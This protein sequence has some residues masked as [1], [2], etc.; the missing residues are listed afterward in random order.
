[1]GDLDNSK[2]YDLRNTNLIYELQIKD[3][4]K[5]LTLILGILDKIGI[6]EISGCVCLSVTRFWGDSKEAL[7]L[8]VADVTWEKR[9]LTKKEFSDS[10]W[11]SDDIQSEEDLS[12]FLIMNF[13]GGIDLKIICQ[14]YKIT[15]LTDAIF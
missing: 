1:M 15:E 10:V 7:D 2:Y 8:Y 5:T 14:D 9:K 12:E 4:Q 13:F 6:L 3:D 11:G